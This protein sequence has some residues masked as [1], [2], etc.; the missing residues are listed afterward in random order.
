MV[1]AAHFGIFLILSFFYNTAVATDRCVYLKRS[2]YPQERSLNLVFVPSGFGNDLEGY[3][4]AIR[5]QWPTI[6]QFDPFSDGVNSL[7]VIIAK[8]RGFSRNLCRPHRNISRVFDCNKKRG[9]QLAN[10]CISN[11]NRHVMIVNNSGVYGASGLSEAS[12]INIHNPQAGRQIV[13]ELGHALFK[14]SDEYTDRNASV[15]GQ[16]CTSNRSCVPWQDLISAGLATC[17]PGC[18]GN[19]KFTSEDTIM[20]LLSSN[21]FGHV[22]TR[23]ICCVFKENTGSYPQM[24]DTYRHIGAGLDAFCRSR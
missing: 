5:Q 14:L 19:L 11:T 16:N 6:S 10:T 8:P 21:T 3:E 12:N 9:R 4:A 1:R 2:A 7:N 13:H 24:C 17:R 15:I 22:N 18:R 23:L 20:D